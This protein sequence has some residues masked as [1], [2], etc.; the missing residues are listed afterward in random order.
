M[1]NDMKYLC[2]RIENTCEN[3]NRLLD[4]TSVHMHTYI[5]TQNIII[6][7]C[8]YIVRRLFMMFLL[9]Q[10]CIKRWSTMAWSCTS[11]IG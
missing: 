8:V 7:N 11:I 1:M 2:V 5:C 4:Q 3:H 9:L 10:V 6:W